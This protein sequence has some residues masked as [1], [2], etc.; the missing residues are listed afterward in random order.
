MTQACPLGAGAVV[1]VTGGSGGP[2]TSASVKTGVGASSG[3]KDPGLTTSK[4]PPGW[5]GA[6]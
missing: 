5:T 3:G 2:V 4:R 6:M 1:D